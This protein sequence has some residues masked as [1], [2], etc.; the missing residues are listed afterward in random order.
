[1]AR[2]RRAQFHPVAGLLLALA[3]VLGLTAPAA[4]LQ[5]TPQA[6]PEAGLAGGN[7]LILFTADGARQDLIDGYI[8]E[9]LLPAYADLVA[10]GVQGE[11]GMLQCF[12]P[13]TGVGWA[14][15]STGTWP[16]EHGST[17]NTSCRAGSPDLATGTSAYAPGVLQADT[18]G[19]AAERAGKT[20]VAVEW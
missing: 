3:L 11:N 9:G 12:P 6:S 15:I 7:P 4:G 19:Q 17:N 16:S 14:T 2:L 10:T 13:S 5:G 8:A 1:M 20:V 18:I